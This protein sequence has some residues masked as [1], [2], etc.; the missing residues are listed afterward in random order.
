[1]ALGGADAF[2]NHGLLLVLQR[3]RDGT[4]GHAVIVLY[5]VG[6]G[7]VGAALDG[8][9]RD[10]DNLAHGIDEHAG[11]DELPGPK[12]QVGIR[13]LGLHAHGARRLVD[14]IV[15]HLQTAAVE[16]GLAVGLQ[17]LDHN[18]AAGEGRIDV[19][20]LLL[21]EG[22]K[23]RNRPDLGYDDNAGV[24]SAHQVAFI[25]Q[26]DTGAPLKRSHDTG[27]VE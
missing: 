7:A 10:H 23:D 16:H 12:L 26:A 21:R 13:K 25:D 20:E 3:Q 22:E 24:R 8:G 18:G 17:R 14:L 6:E 1:D 9:R 2:R 15:N 11:I 5:D 27:V 19:F 4:Q